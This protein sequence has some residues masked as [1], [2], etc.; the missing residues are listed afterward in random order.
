MSNHKLAKV[1]SLLLAVLLLG[2]LDQWLKYYLG[3]LQQGALHWGP[4][5]LVWHTNPG[6]A[7]SINLP[8][9]LAITLV[10]ILLS[11]LIMLFW[12]SQGRGLIYDGGLLLVIGGGASNLWDKLHWGFV[13]DFVSVGWLPIFNLADVFIFVGIIMIILGVSYGER[14]TFRRERYQKI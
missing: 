5:D 11:V 9:P 2:G 1:G 12:W 14:Q 6:I 13:R 8:A 7:F 10:I 3:F 4:V